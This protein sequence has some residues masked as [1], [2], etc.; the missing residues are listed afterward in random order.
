VSEEP[1]RTDVFDPAARSA[2]MR[3]VKGRDT[4]PELRVRQALTVLGARYRLHRK[5][6]PG[7]PDIV[8]PGRRLVLFVHGCFWH[9]H[10]HCPD[11]KMPKSKTDWWTAKIAGNRARDARVENELRTLGWHVV[12]LWACAVKTK[13]A[14]EWLESRLPV[15]IGRP[16]S[17]PAKVQRF[18]PI[19]SAKIAEDLE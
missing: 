12:T 9:G 2:V 18:A 15:L 17:L 3:K 11:F 19:I 13:S 7:S 14:R 8:L 10:E 6:L 4:G 5:D 1:P 16:L